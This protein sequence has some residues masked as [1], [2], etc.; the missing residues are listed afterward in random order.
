MNEQ[1]KTMTDFIRDNSAYL[2]KALENPDTIE[3][4]TL[5]D[6]M[7]MISIK[8]QGLPDAVLK[9]LHSLKDCVNLLGN[10]TSLT[11]DQK[12]ENEQIQSVVNVVYKILNEG[13]LKELSTILRTQFNEYCHLPN[14]VAG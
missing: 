2:E 14:K 11:A 9:Y 7:T 3:G 4:K 8:K 1:Q 12:I 10:D 13:R 5:W 6:T